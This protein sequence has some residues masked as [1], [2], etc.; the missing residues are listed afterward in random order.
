LETHR[1]THIGF[2]IIRAQ[3]VAQSIALQP[4]P[5]RGGM[6]VAFVRSGE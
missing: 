2:D 4:V 5:V 6:M 3:I 1:L